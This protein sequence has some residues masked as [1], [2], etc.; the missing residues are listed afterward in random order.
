MLISATANGGASA[1]EARRSKNFPSWFWVLVISKSGA[2]E[3]Q[4]QSSADMI[5]PSSVSLDRSD[6][7]VSASQCCGGMK[8]SGDKR[9]VGFN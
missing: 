2:L 8:A 7:V 3:A 4:L 9:P 6:S 1:H 5:K